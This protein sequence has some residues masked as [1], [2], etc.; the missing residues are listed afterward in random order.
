MI[1]SLTV[2]ADH[3]ALAD[4]R[5]PTRD[6]IALAAR[7]HLERIG[8][9]LAGVARSGIVVLRCARSPDGCLDCVGPDTDRIAAFVAAWDRGE[10]PTL[11]QHFTIE[12]PDEPRRRGWDKPQ[13]I[14]SNGRVRPDAEAAPD[15]PGPLLF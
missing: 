10:T 4:R 5:N 12:V 15:G 14:R 9:R 2:T 13:R 8:R 3:A 1:V 7:P 11:P 6:P